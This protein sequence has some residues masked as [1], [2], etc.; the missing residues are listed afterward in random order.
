M[1]ERKKELTKII[2]E[3]NELA[4]K[5]CVESQQIVINAQIELDDLA[6]RELAQKFTEQQD[7]DYGFHDQYDQ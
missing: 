4:E 6:D 3:H 1:K 5:G 7:Y 2:H